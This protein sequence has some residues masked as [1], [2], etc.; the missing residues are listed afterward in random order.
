MFVTDYVSWNKLKCI[1]AGGSNFEQCCKNKKNVSATVLGNAYRVSRV[2]SLP[3]APSFEVDHY[4]DARLW[5]C[6]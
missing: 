4:V 6:L 1:S 3:F 5:C 2:A